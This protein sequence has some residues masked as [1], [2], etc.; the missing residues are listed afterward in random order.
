MDF[1]DLL[2]QL[3]GLKWSP[4]TSYL[5]QLQAEKSPVAHLHPPP[6]RACLVFSLQMKGCGRRGACRD[7]ALW[8][9]ARQGLTVLPGEQG[10]VQSLWE[11]KREAAMIAEL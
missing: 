11:M 6:E 3:R 10:L 1:G 4:G 5:R 9:A 8:P 2:M 7:P